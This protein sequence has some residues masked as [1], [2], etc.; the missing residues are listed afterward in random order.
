MH[1]GQHAAIIDRTTFEAVQTRLHA[2]AVTRKTGRRNTSFLLAGLLFD[3]RGHRMTPT[4]ANKR[5]V[6]YRYYVSQSVLQNRKTEA[7]TIAQVAAPD[8]ETLAVEAVRRHLVNLN[9]PELDG[10]TTVQVIGDPLSGQ[11][12]NLIVAHIARV[13]V[14]ATQIKIILRN[15]LLDDTD[16]KL[17][18]LTMPWN[19]KA[20]TMRKGTASAPSGNQHLDP[21]TRDTLL[22]AIGRARIWLCDLT[23]GRVSSFEEIARR[24]GKGERHV[25]L[26]A[27]LAFVSPR[28]VAAIIEGNAPAGLTVTGLARALP[29]DWPAQERQIGIA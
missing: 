27:A 11:D 25:R 18:K 24:E 13:I 28:L 15:A 4:H 9:K 14:G 1:T 10:A 20:A 26:L 19:P 22:A 7:G 6:R 5:G 2:A 8:I 12:R 23:D 16:K 3:D 21:N 29:A 17:L